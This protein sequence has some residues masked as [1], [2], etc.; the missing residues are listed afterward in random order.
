VIELFEHLSKIGNGTVA[1]LQ[2]KHGLPF[3]LEVEHPA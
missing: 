1:S 2:I 3:K